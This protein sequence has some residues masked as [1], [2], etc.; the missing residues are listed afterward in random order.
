VLARVCRERVA[1]PATRAT[2]GNHEVS[3]PPGGVRPLMF[4]AGPLGPLSDQLHFPTR[5]APSLQGAVP[6]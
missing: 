5:L 6:H 1:L 2:R 4:P 3:G